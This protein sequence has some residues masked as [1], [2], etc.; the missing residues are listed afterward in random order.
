MS[1]SPVDWGA[2]RTMAGKASKLLQSE[3]RG[4]GLG[5]IVSVDAEHA[6]VPLR[7]HEGRVALRR[8]AREHPDRHIASRIDQFLDSVERQLA[9]GEDPWQTR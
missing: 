4:D 1:D 9:N 3:A 8:Y 7:T 2:L 6:I 5:G